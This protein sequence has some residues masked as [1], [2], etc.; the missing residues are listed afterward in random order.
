MKKN[1]KKPENGIWGK[2]YQ[3][4][5]YKYQNIVDSYVFFG[6]PLILIAVVINSLIFSDANFQNKLTGNDIYLLLSA[7]I[8]PIFIM[9]Y[10]LVF[11]QN[12]KYFKNKRPRG[13]VKEIKVQGFKV[14]ITP[15]SSN[16]S[17]IHNNIALKS[18]KY[19][20]SKDLYFDGKSYSDSYDR[21]FISR[22][23]EGYIDL[24]GSFKGAK[25]GGRS[26]IDTSMFESTLVQVPDSNNPGENVLDGTPMK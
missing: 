16:N 1:L 10:F 7:I 5:I 12:S 4:L 8:F 24:F 20:D 15:Y 21:L 13:L 3:K 26:S 2:G 6:I 11:Y 17:V 25:R 14:K 9:H 23:N 19:K 22:L 18:D